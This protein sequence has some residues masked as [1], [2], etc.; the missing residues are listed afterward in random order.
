[1]H[2]EYTNSLRQATKPVLSQEKFFDGH[3][4]PVLSIF[5]TLQLHWETEI[6]LKTHF[7]VQ[8]QKQSLHGDRKEQDKFSKTVETQ[9]EA[10]STEKHEG[11]Q[12]QRK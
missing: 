5:C 7:S 1:M 11:L 10:E 4:I 12:V 2:S 3:V 6:S 8:Q 9:S